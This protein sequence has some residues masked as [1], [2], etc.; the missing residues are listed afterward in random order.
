[1]FVVAKSNMLNYYLETS[2]WASICMIEAMKGDRQLIKLFAWYKLQA[3]DLAY[4]EWKFYFS[5]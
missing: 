2:E 4:S 1:M 3:L 5:S